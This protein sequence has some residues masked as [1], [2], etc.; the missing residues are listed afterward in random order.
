LGKGTDRF[1]DHLVGQGSPGGHEN[2]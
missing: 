2:Q 1:F